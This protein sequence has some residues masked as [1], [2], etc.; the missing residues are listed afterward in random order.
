M[1][2][3]KKFV[4][5]PVAVGLFSCALFTPFRA[6]ANEAVTA[7]NMV[8]TAT[9]NEINSQ[10]APGA[11][12]VI[13]RQKI[14]QTNARDLSEIL[15][16]QAGVMLQGRTSTGRKTISFRGLNS[17]HTLILV[18]GMRVAASNATIG[19]SDL[20]NNWIPVENIERIE[21]VR[22]PLSALY[23]SEAMGGVINVITK[24]ASP[25]WTGSLTAKGGGRTDG[26]GGETRVLGAQL[27]GPILKDNLSFTLSLE[28]GKEDPA[29][30]KEDKKKSEIEGKEVNTAS[31]GLNL[32]PWKNQRLNLF[33]NATDEERENHA[34]SRGK[35]YEDIYDISKYQVGAQVDSKIGA[36]ATGVKL[37][38][39]RIEKEGVKTYEDGTVK[40]S[41]DELIN[42]VADLQSSFMALGTKLT[43]GGEAR[44]EE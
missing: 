11:I 2:D 40:N 14:E 16:D 32:A 24:K 13:S 41:Y 18:N 21:V 37:Y 36:V 29:P 42:D 34:L 15:R 31:L 35:Y 27:S 7:E 33:V 38:R 19:H 5:T 12:T 23:G 22:G 26:N 4:Y 30:D 28:H 43:L 8:V 6:M 39:S 1:K 44:R 20:E 3:W 9:R 25:Q 17:K 10:D